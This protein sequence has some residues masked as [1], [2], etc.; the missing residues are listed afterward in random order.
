MMN[1]ELNQQ[2]AK[3]LQSV[4]NYYGKVLQ[5]TKD[6][7]TSACCSAESLPV[8]LREIV[9]QVHPEILDRFYGCGSPFPPALEGRTVLDLG[10]GSGRDVYLLSKLVGPRGRVL[11]IDMTDEQ[12]EV[13]RRHQDWHAER[14][15]SEKSNVQFFKGYIEDLRGAGIADESVDLVVSNCVTN[16]SPDKPSLFREVWRVL[17]PGGELY[18]SDVFVD[19]RL[20][21]VLAEDPILLGECLG[22]ALYTED[23]R[24][25]M[26]AL[27]C[28][29]I[30]MVSQS[31]LDILDPSI[32]AKLGN[33]QFR[34]I[35]F[36]IFKM[37]LE[38][39]CED[40]GQVA[41][42]RGTIPELPHRFILDD[43][44]LFETN[45]PMT[46]C[47]NTAD[48]LSRS[49]YREHFQVWGDKSLHF[50]LFPCGPAPVVPNGEGSA[51]AAC[52]PGACC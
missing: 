21:A 2:S 50:G 14:F 15:G 9:K 29:D 43:H 36:R 40:H 24:R 1:P 35:T 31:P 22:A 48:M 13:A 34:S 28:H 45:R 30:R 17:K 20:P 6:L 52:A 42:Y 18:F 3:T 16:L 49:A 26:N 27:G 8:H 23:F 10:C 12:L 4:Q 39:K 33:A 46:V 51:A 32:R 7:K 11:G 41:V 38:D 25:I 47:G 44:H 19:R 5:H 37:E